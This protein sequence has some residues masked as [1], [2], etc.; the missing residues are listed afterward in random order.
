V[1]LILLLVGYTELA[2]LFNHQ[3]GEIT[4]ALAARDGPRFW[5]SILAFFGLLV[6]GV[7][8]DAYYFYIVDILALNWRRWLTDRFLSRYFKDHRYYQ[9]LSKPEIDNPDQRIS[10]DINSFTERFLSFV[11][12]FANALFQLVAFGGVLWSIS[13]HLVLFLFIYAAGVTATMFGIFGEKMVSLHYTQRWREADF[14][15]GLVRVREN[16]EAIAFYRGERHE[17]QRLQQ[18]FAKLFANAMQIIRWSLG[19]NFFYYGNSY[20]TMVLPTLI[21]A[22]R[23]LS[24]ELEVGR[25]VQA[26]GA[27]S[28]VLS[29][30][31]ILVDNLDGLSR[32][33]ASVGRLETFA[34][35]LSRNPLHIPLMEYKSQIAIYNN[36]NCRRG[37]T[38]YGHVQVGKI[39]SQESEDLGFENV[40]LNTPS[41]ERTLIK[42]LTVSI[43]CGKGLMIV[44]A[45]GLG[46]SSL[47]R[48]IAGLWDAGDG[49]LMRP[50]SKDMLFLP[51][52]AY[53]AVGS[54]RAQLNYPNLNGF[55]TDEELREA[56]EL[57][58]LS[59]LV[60]RCGGFDADFDFDKILSAGERQRIAFA[61]VFLKTPRYVLLDEA[62]SALD[63][64]NETALYERLLATSATLVTVSHHP[65][66]VKYHSNVLEL[67]V[68]GDWCLHTAADFRFTEDLG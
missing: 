36:G 62:T 31:T 30:L 47:L 11:L 40:T 6:V 32:F 5:R 16:A 26:T 61:R 66:L 28:A 50:R 7:P 14:R 19:L 48:A 63:R 21:I 51:Q 37:I 46:K 56:L 18:V 4:S 45:S 23:V 10:D 59:G 22:P 65:A 27:F 49:V 3:S 1:L 25:I 52:H 9:L 34:R 24:G 53:M 33:A 12:V 41:G 20:L 13:R 68:N 54:L 43:P 15:F 29:A 60:E 42:N 17:R 44:G 8:V 58:N 39:H 57:V 55:V 64:E 67:K 35:S 38:E 2:V